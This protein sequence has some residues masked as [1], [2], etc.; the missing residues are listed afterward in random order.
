MRLAAALGEHVSS[1]NKALLYTAHNS[2]Q[3]Q[4]QHCCS[5][6]L[7]TRTTGRQAA[8]QHP[9]LP[10]PCPASPG[11]PVARLQ[12]LR[13]GTRLQA[14]RAGT[15]LQALRAGSCAACHP[16]PPAALPL[17]PAAAPPLTWQSCGQHANLLGDAVAA[18]HTAG[19]YQ[20]V[21]DLGGGGAAAAAGAQTSSSSNRCSKCVWR[22][23]FQWCI[24]G[25]MQ[26]CH[27]NCC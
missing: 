4:P 20:L 5:M 14:L 1:C 3:Y 9:L 6:C 13:A 12:A 7:A 17:L 2:W 8:A 26:T 18:R 19:V 25:R 22:F 15:R 21:L 23:R 11:R 27:T 10:A 16:P 24:K